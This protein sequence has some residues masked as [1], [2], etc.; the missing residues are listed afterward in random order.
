MFLR[1]FKN[2]PLFKR[3]ILEAEIIGTVFI[4]V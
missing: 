1:L 3:W 4:V 2:E